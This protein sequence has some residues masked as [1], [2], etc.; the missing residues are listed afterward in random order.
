MRFSAAPSLAI[1]APLGERK[2]VNQAGGEAYTQSAKVELASLVLSSMLKDRF[3]AK[4]DEDLARARA[5]VQ[6]LAKDGDA[7]FAAKAAIYARRVH[8]LRSITH[9]IAGEIARVC[10]GKEWG[11][12][13]FDQVVFRPDDTCEIL[14]YYCATYGRAKIPN[15]MRRGLG[16]ALRRFE[17]YSLSKWSGGSG[18][19]KL[20]DVVNLC[21]PKATEHLTA[22]M[23]GT[24]APADTWER[25]LSG[26]GQVAASL[27]DEGNPD[28]LKADEWR[29]LLSE[30]KLPY[31]ACLRNIR[32]IVEQAPDCVELAS[33]LL[34]NPEA[35]QKSKVFPFQFGTAAE[36][37]A[38][39]TGPGSR[40]AI[41]A[42]I[43][44]CDLSLA[45]VPTFDGS[46]LIVVDASG[47]MTS[48]EKP[49]IKI[50]ALFAAALY[51]SNKNADFMLF[52][53]SAAYANFGGD[54]RVLY[55]ASAIFNACKSGGTNFH[56]IFQTANR[57]YDRI[58]ILSDMQGWMG[59]NTPT[60]EFEAYKKR[61]NADP[62][63][64]SFD[65]NGHGTTQLPEGKI[66]AISGWSDKAF[67]LMKI[68]EQDRKALVTTIEAVNA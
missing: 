37:L 14:G 34:T 4:A 61:H 18:N 52:S 68:A 2:A 44:A 67:D 30:K 7:L 21:R 25:A 62:F 24:L 11:K 15:A 60:A 49:P 9:V 50:A 27:G 3:H 16:M 23:K 55:L 13:F 20:V 29:R 63:I 41:E 6:Q 64:Y 43:N 19:L 42:V 45:N 32:N 33:A 39:I 66:I 56:A 58:V 10:Q 17:A 28:K 5:L 53:D 48:G 57:A 40:A 51:R 47:S 46:T 1:P 54:Q 38:G 36:A 22:L 12:R 26:A 59:G 35:V 31:F 65:L 8:G